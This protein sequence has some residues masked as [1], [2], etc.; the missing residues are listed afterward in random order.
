MVSS[1]FKENESFGVKCFHHATPLKNCILCALLTDKFFHIR[2]RF[3]MTGRETYVQLHRG[4][5]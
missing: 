4:L 3:K 1:N 2:V 5:R